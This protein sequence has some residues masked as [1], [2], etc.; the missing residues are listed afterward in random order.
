MNRLAGGI[1]QVNSSLDMA[2]SWAR[3]K[4]Y[5][6]V[7]ARLSFAMAE[8]L[9]ALGNWS[10]AAVTLE[11]GQSRLQDARSGIL[12]NWSQ[13]LTARVLYQQGRKSASAALAQ[14]VDGQI[15]MAPRNLQ[16]GLANTWF[17]QQQLRP[18]SAVDVYGALLADPTPADWV[19]RPLETLAFMETPHGAAFDRWLSA[20]VS[21]K[22]MGTALEVT[23]LAKRR[24][25]HSA[26][27][28]GGKLAALRDTL[29]APESMLSQSALSRRN[30]LLL[31]YP[32]YDQAL[33]AGQQ[34]RA[35]LQAT[36]LDGLDERAERDLTKLWRE[37]SASLGEREAMLG[38]I[39]MERVAADP[40]FPPLSTT[41]EL[42]SKLQPGQAV[43]VFHNTSNGLLG[44]LVTSGASTHW[45]CGPM[46]RLYAPMHEF[47]RTL[48]N[49]D[50]NHN[51][52]DKELGS[53]DW[54]VA[55]EKLF[56]ALFE[57][58]SI[59]PESLKE[60]VV[61]PDGMVWYVPLAALPVKTEERAVPLISVS[62]LRVVPTMGLAFGHA[63]PWRRVQRS[64]VVGMGIVPGETD[65]EQREALDS[66]RSAVTNPIEIP[67][68][69]PIPTPQ[70][71][72]LLETLIVLDQV[73]LDP[74]QPMAWSP[75]AQ[76][77]S[78][79]QSTLSHW[80]TLPQIGPQRI[81]LPGVH[82]IAERGGKTS[83]RRNVQTLPGHEIFLASCG[84]MSTGTQTI[85]L[86]RWNVGGQSTL[87]ILRE[88]VQ[89]LPHTTAADAWQRSVQVA[90]ELPIDP[91][92]EP[93]VKTGR[94]D[95]PLTAAHPFFWGGYLL[96]DAGSPA[97]EEEPQGNAEVRE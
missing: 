17:D 24:R 39:G 62:K 9:M 25:Y 64:G 22:D 20:Y 56:H 27:A 42:Q 8:E 82:T 91:N 7:F 23:D 60:L 94:K 58:S 89:E 68:P 12:G 57:G 34:L 95:S 50:A 41:A 35:T 71:A 26:L 69:S 75:L 2:A 29:E 43:V 33:K 36:W 15:T 53:S 45:N 28:W 72:S 74:A 92:V 51:L 97:E 70:V 90:L 61:I 19:F 21:R 87:D 86:S 55:G 48:G 16:I 80:L 44:F 31:R 67:S 88:F 59:D 46:G 11:K 93:R 38:H 54:L 4:R 13:Y 18:R 66:L 73:V 63:I 79:K 76:G 37:W 47:L 5:D 78:T 96:I 40:Q 3:R 14:A 10:E 1:G 65:D 32:N 83:K 49:Y 6:H 77:R 52:T 85:L 84:L 30:E 81:L